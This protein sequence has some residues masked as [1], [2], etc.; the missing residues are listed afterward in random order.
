M[1]LLRAS[2]AVA[3]GAVPT[4][5]GGTALAGTPRYFQANDAAGLLTALQQIARAALG[6]E[7]H[8]AS[9]PADASRLF[10]YVNG[11]LQNRDVTHAGG[12]DYSLATGHVSFA[13]GLCTLVATDATARVSIVTGCR[14]DGLAERRDGGAGLPAGAACG[15]NADCTS[16]V[17]AAGT[18][19]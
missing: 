14:D 15:G 7:Y 19:G 1:R 5:T 8:L 13:G 11:V 16:G 2:L 10:V 4:R 12:W 6:C 17:C 9:A 3:V 18:C